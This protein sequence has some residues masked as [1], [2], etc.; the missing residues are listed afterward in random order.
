MKTR[1]FL[2]VAAVAL[3]STVRATRSP[4]AAAPQPQTAIV[5]GIADS[6]PGTLRGA[7]ERASAGTT[8]TFD[9]DV[10]APERP[11]TI[12]LL[13]ALPELSQG[14]VTIDAS[15][16]G[17][18]LD[19]SSLP[20]EKGGNGLTISS[21]GNVVSGLQILGFPGHGISIQGGAHNNTIGGNWQ[22]GSGP[23]GQGNVIR[24]NGIEGVHIEGVG[25]DHNL[26][27]GNLIGTDETGTS[28]SGNGSHGVAIIRGA[29]QNQVGGAAAAERNVVS[30]NAWDGVFIHYS[31]TMYNRVT[32]N[33]IGTDA[34]GT[35]PIPNG[36][37]GI[38]LGESAQANLIGGPAAGEGNVVSGNRAGGMNVAGTNVTDNTIRGNYIGVDVHGSQALANARGVVIG[39]GATSNILQGN[40][41]S[42]NEIDG[43]VIA[44][45]ATTGNQVIGNFVGVSASGTVPIGNGASGIWIGEGTQDNTIGGSEP[46]KRNIISGGEEN[47]VVVDGASHNTISG[48]FIGTDVSGT[49]AVGNANIGV[50]L[51]WG[52]QYNLVGGASPA[53]RNLISGNGSVGVSIADPNTNWNTLSGNYIGTDVSGTKPI[54]NA[55]IG[56]HLN[57]GASHN[58]VGGTSPGEDNLISGNGGDGVRIDHGDTIGN[59]VAGNCI[60][61]DPSGKA[62]LGNV[63]DGVHLDNGARLNVIGPENTI[64]YNGQNGVGVLGAETLGNTITA[65]SIYQNQGLAILNAQGGNAELPVPTIVYVSTRTVRGIATPNSRVEVFSDDGRQGRVFEGAIDA[66]QQGRF[67]FRMPQGRLTGPNVTATC[68]D[69][70]GNT[71]ELSSPGAPPEPLITRELPNIVAPAQVS[72]QPKVVGTNLSLALFCLLFFGLTSNIF[73]SILKDHREDLVRSAG[74]LVPQAVANAVSGIGSSLV[75]R[76][77]TGRG[78]LILTWLALLLLTSVIESFLDPALGVFT[79]DRLGLL[80]TLFVSALFVSALESGSD[81]LAHRTWAPTTKVESKVQWIG[82]AIALACVMLSRTLDFKPGYLYGIVGAV[83]FVPKL[84][85]IHCCG[86]RAALV[87]I[88]I[89]LGGFILWIASAFLPAALADLEPLFLTTFL[90]GLEGVFFAL[91]PLAF[92]DGGDIWTWRRSVWLAFFAVVLFCFYHFVLNPHASDVRALQQNGVQTLLAL[93]VLFG[94]ATL[95]LWVVFPLRKGRRKADL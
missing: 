45:A 62:D 11:A 75:D 59:S 19:G 88:S 50:V 94:M 68:I 42:G 39:N 58:I 41:I 72:L 91:I 28:A 26:V 77:K 24:G 12:L 9:P 83:Y 29:Q 93:V 55:E 48:N 10:F 16:A 43:V 44:G 6:G 1:V 8:I 3:A 36:N 79:V 14:Q 60:G 64:A 37:F 2:V 38:N 27:I 74:R 22:V 52:A 89:L 53:E 70:D 85:E 15:D 13:S 31:G 90:I 49:L 82:L 35:A 57:N 67:T 56:V 95:I 30:G 5:T 63:G 33:H 20:R 73:N 65:N 92:T 4:A 18:I 80:I 71:S 84:A 86:K 32:G 81:L 17:V 46:G 40:V 76:A 61:T 69:A 54:G 87:L 23:T 7:L 47:G 21:S 78:G 51:A 25:T 34:S 66:D